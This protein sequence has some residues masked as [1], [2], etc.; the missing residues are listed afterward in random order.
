MQCVLSHLQ[1]KTHTIDVFETDTE[2]D[3]L[4]GNGNGRDS[5][6]RSRFVALIKAEGEPK[7]DASIKFLLFGSWMV[8]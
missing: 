5:S 8:S 2:A 1:M 4:L 7:W 3:P 6:L